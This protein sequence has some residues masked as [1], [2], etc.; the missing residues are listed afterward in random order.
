M[1]L[2]KARALLA[3]TQL[4]EE[5]LTTFWKGAAASLAPWIVMFKDPGFKEERNGGSWLT[6]AWVRLL[7]IYW[8]GARSWQCMLI[9]NKSSGRWA[10]PGGN[11]KEIQPWQS[12]ASLV[13][14]LPCQGSAPNRRANRLIG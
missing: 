6:A 12:P 9:S 8:T 2:D 10:R 7:P 14:A 13:G 4:S 5:E 3:E 11:R 1:F